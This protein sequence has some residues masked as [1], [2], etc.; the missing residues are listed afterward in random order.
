MEQDQLNTLLQLSSSNMNALNEQAMSQ[1]K[2]SSLKQRIAAK[3]EE[4]KSVV[5]DFQSMSTQLTQIKTDFDKQKS[6]GMKKLQELKAI[7]EDI[8]LSK[9]F[10][11]QSK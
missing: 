2:I 4:V 9:L 11:R 1:A 8:T 3:K 5:S 6:E 7:D 10:E